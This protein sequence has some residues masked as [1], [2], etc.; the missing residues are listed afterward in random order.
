MMMSLLLLLLLSD[1]TLSVSS[2]PPGVYHEFDPPVRVLLTGGSRCQMQ[3][4]RLFIFLSNGLVTMGVKDPALYTERYLQNKSTPTG[5]QLSFMEFHHSNDESKILDFIERY[6][7]QN[8]RH[9]P[10]ITCCSPHAHCTSIPPRAPDHPL[11]ELIDAVERLVG[12][13]DDDR[14]FV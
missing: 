8:D 4:A 13:S 12:C 6:R 1:A 14:L 10:H 5:R 9:I 2:Q 7:E 11:S 3:K